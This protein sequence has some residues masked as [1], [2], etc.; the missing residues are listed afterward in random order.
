MSESDGKK[1]ERYRA[2]PIATAASD[3]IRMTQKATHAYRKAGS[4]PK[5]SRKKTYMPPAFGIIAPI[6]A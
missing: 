3:P 5:A 1:T 6:S 2:N 4:S